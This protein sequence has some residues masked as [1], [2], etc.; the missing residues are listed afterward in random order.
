MSYVEPIPTG[1]RIFTGD[2][3][4]QIISRLG[5]NDSNDYIVGV[6]F[7]GSVAIVQPVPDLDSVQTLEELN[8]IWLDFIERAEAIYGPATKVYPSRRK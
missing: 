2:N 1:F 5:L 8:S 6:N 7:H 4:Q 3:Q